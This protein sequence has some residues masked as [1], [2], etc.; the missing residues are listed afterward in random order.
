MVPGMSAAIAGIEHG[1]PEVEV[2]AVRIA[3]IDSEVPVAVAPVEWAIEV[4]GIDEGLPLPVEQHIAHVQIAA[5]PVGA[6]HIVVAGH[7]H[8]I[9]EVDLVGGLILLVGEVQLVGHL[10][11]QEQGLVSGLLVAHG[12]ARSCSEQHH[13]QGYHHLCHSRIL[14]S[15]STSMVFFSLLQR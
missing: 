10:V 8:Q 5:L 13:G 9:V 14:F 11:G 7:P 4:G 15:G 6:V 3:Q 1:A 12:F 2:V